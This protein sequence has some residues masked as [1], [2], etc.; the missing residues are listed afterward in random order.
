MTEETTFSREISTFKDIKDNY[1]KTILTLDRFT[2]GN[3]DGIVVTNVI[4]WLM[5]D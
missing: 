3:Y 2:V 4:D 1:K 5:Q